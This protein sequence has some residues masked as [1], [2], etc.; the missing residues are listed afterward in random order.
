MSTNF[1]VINCI[2]SYNMIIWRPWIHDMRVVPSTL[3]QVAI[4][5]SYPS[6]GIKEIKRDQKNY[7]SYYPPTLKGKSKGL[8]TIT[9]KASSSTHIRAIG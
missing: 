4:Q 3:H 7:F 5:I 2:S 6:W 8:I 9:A 1:V